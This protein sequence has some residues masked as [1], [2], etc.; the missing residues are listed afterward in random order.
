MHIKIGWLKPSNIST[1]AGRERCQTSQLKVK[2]LTC[3]LL[4]Q[5]NWTWITRAG[6]R[7]IYFL[8]TDC[9]A[10]IP[11]SIEKRLVIRYQISIPM[12]LISS[13]SVG[14]FPLPFKLRKLQ[15]RIENTPNRNAS[16]SRSVSLQPT[17]SRGRGWIQIQLLPPYIYLNLPISTP[18]SK[19]PPPP[20]STPKSTNI[21]TLDVDPIT[22][23]GSCGLQ[24]NAPRNLRISIRCF[25]LN[26]FTLAWGG[27]SGNS[28]KE[29]L[30]KLQWN[31]FF[32]HLQVTWHM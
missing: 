11:S 15:L 25:F 23:P 9:I 21:H 12:G 18:I 30:A 27:F 3:L 29:Y 7:A 22:T 26:V 16:I 28:I 2:L 4:H 17:R 8:G 6:Y 24:R 20:I 1:I 10:S 31:F 13:A 19:P 5:F 32:L 14:V